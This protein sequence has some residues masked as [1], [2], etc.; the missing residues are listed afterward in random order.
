MKA[1]FA[2]PSVPDRV[3]SSLFSGGE[4]VIRESDPTPYIFSLN[5]DGSMFVNL[6]DYLLCPIEMFTPRQRKA[7]MKKYRAARGVT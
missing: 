4:M 7:A 3:T 1:I 5:E 2:G 6:H